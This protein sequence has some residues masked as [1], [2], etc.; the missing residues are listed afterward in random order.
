MTGS[1]PTEL[2]PAEA[3]LAW[4]LPGS[5]WTK[6]TV[7]RRMPSATARM[8]SSASGSA[9]WANRFSCCS[10]ASLRASSGTSSSRAIS[11][12]CDQSAPPFMRFVP[13][14]ARRGR[15][16]LTARRIASSC[17]WAWKSALDRMSI[18]SARSSAGSASASNSPELGRPFAP[19]SA[20][21]R[22]H[23]HHRRSPLRSPGAGP[24]RQRCRSGRCDAC[25]HGPHDLISDSPLP[26]LVHQGLDLGERCPFASLSVAVGYWE[27]MSPA[28]GEP[29]GPRWSAETCCRERKTLTM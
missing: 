15:R 27:P 22:W 24:L 21:A 23:P 2:Q 10:D 7:D 1:M 14:E 9:A 29:W 8:T 26:Q 3:L 17:S 25:R 18:G 13:V 6:R 4:H 20:R 5:D 16:K 19:A 12:P 11:Q 28:S